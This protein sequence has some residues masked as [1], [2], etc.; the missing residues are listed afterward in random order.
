MGDAGRST[1]SRRR[2]WL[3]GW[4]RAIFF[5]PAA[6]KPMAHPDP[7]HLAQPA[8]HIVRPPHK[9]PIDWL[10]P[11]P[12]GGPLDAV[13]KPRWYEPARPTFSTA[14]AQIGNLVLPREQR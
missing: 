6:P 9:S 2:S 12:D 1:G 10:P 3:P 4:L 13:G 8:R 5:L 11:G 14:R 7:H